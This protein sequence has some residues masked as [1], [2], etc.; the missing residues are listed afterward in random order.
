MF[1]VWR[2]RRDCGMGI[3]IVIFVER[4]GRIYGK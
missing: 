4:L 2:V 1:I 3:F